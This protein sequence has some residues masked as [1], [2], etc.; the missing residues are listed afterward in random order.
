MIEIM[1][2]LEAV[3]H[4]VTSRWVKTPDDVSGQDDLTDIDICDLLLAYNP[5][6]F[7]NAGTG[8]RHVEFGYAIAQQKLIAL[9]GNR[10]NI[11]HYLSEVEVYETLE[12][13]LRLASKV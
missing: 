1:T 9:I 4:I 12:A 10:S 8:G 13:F 11:F 5:P 3:G 2:E 7:E 6:E